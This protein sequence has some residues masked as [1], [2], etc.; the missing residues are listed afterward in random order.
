MGIIRK[1][2]GLVVVLVVVIAVIIG[3]GFATG[4]FGVPEVDG[5]ENRFGTVNESVTMIETDIRL[6]NPNPIGIS[7]G[8]VSATYTISMNDVEMASGKKEG[9]SVGSGASTVALRTRLENQRIPEWWVEHVRNDEETTVA[10]AGRVN[11]SLLGQSVEIPTADRTIETDI[12]AALNSEETRPINAD[13]PPVSDPVLYLN[14]TRGS[15]GEVNDSTTEI[16]MEFVVYNPKPYAV[17]VSELSYNMTMNDIAVGSG[18]SANTTLIEPGT[19]EE[20]HT[21]TLMRN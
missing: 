2:I 11:S 8:G 5:I 17:P 16:D 7:L 21:T 9:I 3:A 19:T 13:S 15:W 4:V 12:A 6:N 1:A 14:E 20:I 10:V 18:A